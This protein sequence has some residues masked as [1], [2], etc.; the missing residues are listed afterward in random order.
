M[1]GNAPHARETPVTHDPPHERPADKLPLVASAIFLLMPA[2]LPLFFLGAAESWPS[3]A[4]LLSMSLAILLM[5]LL[6]LRVMQ[7]KLGD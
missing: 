7:R 6:I 1:I 2:L 4:L 3:R 5:N